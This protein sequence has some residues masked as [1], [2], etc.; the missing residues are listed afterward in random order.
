MNPKLKSY[1]AM[2]LKL[3]ALQIAFLVIFTMIG[4]MMYAFDRGNSMAT[5]FAGI[6]MFVQTVKRLCIDSLY[7]KEALFYQSV[8]V[9]LTATA[10][11]KLTICSVSAFLSVLCVRLG[12]YENFVLSPLSLLSSFTLGL[13]FAAVMLA[14]ITMDCVNRSKDRGESM[15]IAVAVFVMMLLTIWFI[16]VW[17]INAVTS[18]EM[19][20]VA[21][22][23]FSLLAGLPAVFAD[24]KIINKSYIV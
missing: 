11:V 3:C 21:A 2:N 20:E 19:R 9:S 6:L 4:Y 12:L 17:V 24:I 16:S 7:K 15:V 5:A 1:I 18:P 23:A 22:I 10:V 8:P 14:V 13:M